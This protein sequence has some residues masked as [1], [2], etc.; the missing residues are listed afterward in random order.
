VSDG[1]LR[2]PYNAAE[3]KDKKRM[4]GW[5]SWKDVLGLGR[6]IDFQDHEGTFSIDTT[7][8]PFFR[9]EDHVQLLQSVACIVAHDDS[10]WCRHGSENSLDED[11]LYLFP[12]LPDAK[13]CERFIAGSADDRNIFTVTTAPGATDQSQSKVVKDCDQGYPDEINNALL[14]TRIPC[15]PSMMISRRLNPDT[16][17]QPP[18]VCTHKSTRFLLPGRSRA[19]SGPSS[20]ALRVGCTS[21]APQ[22]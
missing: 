9:Y 18:T 13:A 5:K 11:T 3:G 2:Q 17:A 15:L 12:S 8:I 7:S 4:Y 6:V 21:P 22:L 20:S 16:P 14:G 10:W 19:S 1:F